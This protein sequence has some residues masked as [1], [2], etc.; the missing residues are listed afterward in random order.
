MIKQLLLSAETLEKG[1]GFE[2][3]S[4]LNILQ[5]GKKE[6]EAISSSYRKEVAVGDFRQSLM[7]L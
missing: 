7:E 6:K 5:R 1:G 2:K 4:K 3:E